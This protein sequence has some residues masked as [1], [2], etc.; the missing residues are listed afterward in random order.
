MSRA[1]PVGAG[2]WAGPHGH[3]LGLQSQSDH[4]SGQRGGGR[5]ARV[6]VGTLVVQVRGD[7]VTDNRGILS[8]VRGPDGGFVWKALGTKFTKC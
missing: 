1:P 7:L 5:G 3:L 4:A 6:F 2:R 8:P